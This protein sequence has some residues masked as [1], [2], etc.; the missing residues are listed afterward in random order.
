MNPESAS[1]IKMLSIFL[2]DIYR[3]KKSGVVSIHDDKFS[4]KLILDSGLLVHVDGLAMVNAK[5]VYQVCQIK[6]LDSP[7]S[8]QLLAIGKRAPHA[9]GKFLVEKGLIKKESWQKFLIMRARYHIEAAIRMERPRYNFSENFPQI[10]EDNQIKS[11]FLELMLNSIRGIEE[12]AFFKRHLP[13]PDQFY[14]RVVDNPLFKEKLSLTSDEKTFLLAFQNA[15]NM[16]EVLSSTGLRQSDFSR[17]FYIFLFLGLISPTNRRT[18]EKEEVKKGDYKETINLYLDFLSIIETNLKS[19]LGMECE[20]IFDR[21]RENL[22]GKGSEIFKSVDILRESRDTS[23]KLISDYLSEMI[24]S[25]ES[26]IIVPTIFN[27]FLYPLIANMRRLLGIEITTQ[28]LDE[29]IRVIGYV[30][31][32][33]S[34][35]KLLDYIAKNLQDYLYQVE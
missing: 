14:Q 15:K 24:I 7:Q 3:D 35:D 2:L 32:M 4:I 31:K 19:E 22:T 13:E 10:S 26:P 11:D 33:R 16:E 21:T 23:V 27:N 12:E 28:T 29:M 5:L 17:S 1:K 8:K 30:K 18:A 9:L 25:G 20:R 6:G 34:Q